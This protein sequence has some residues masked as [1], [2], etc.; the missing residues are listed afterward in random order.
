M[1]F[2]VPQYID[3]EDKVAGPLTARQLFW[4]IGMTAVL[5]V[6]WSIFDSG[7]F[8][9]AAV[10]VVLLFLAFAFFRPYGQ[11]LI[12]F[13]GNALFFIVRPK[14]YVWDRPVKHEKN[15][16]DIGKKVTD[17]PVIHKK[18]TAEEIRRLAGIVDEER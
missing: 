13:I 3:V 6:L 2:N 9:A 12:A 10:P 11:P 17:T 7:A 4:M 14:I 18:V 8:F 1:L 5:M 15:T 16:V